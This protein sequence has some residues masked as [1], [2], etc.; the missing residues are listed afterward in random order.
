MA[1]SSSSRYTVPGRAGYSEL[2]A[3]PPPARTAPANVTAGAY[4]ATR[5]P[6]PDAREPLDGAPSALMVPVPLSEAQVI[7]TLPPEPP[8]W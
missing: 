7:H 4:N 1:M 8:L 6:A 3:E 2:G 5:P